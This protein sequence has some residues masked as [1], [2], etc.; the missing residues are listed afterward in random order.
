MADTPSLR[1]DAL[2]REGSSPSSPTTSDSG[3][4]MKTRAIRRHHLKRVKKN[5]SKRVKL[6]WRHPDLA[7]DPKWVGRVANAPQSCSGPCCGNPRHHFH[8]KCNKTIQEQKFMEMERH[9]EVE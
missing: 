3:V 4:K 1:L 2:G 6:H 7:A 5:I 9:E 8:G